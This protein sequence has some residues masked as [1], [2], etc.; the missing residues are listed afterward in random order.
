MSSLFESHKSISS[1]FASHEGNAW[2]ST[3][4]DVRK[5]FVNLSLISFFIIY[6]QLILV[7][8]IT[9]TIISNSLLQFVIV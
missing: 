7:S 9:P 1:S 8:D 5:N 2:F 4:N 6:Q 3:F